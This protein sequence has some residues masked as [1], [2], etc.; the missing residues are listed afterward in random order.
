M[1]LPT[2]MKEFK[3][4]FFFG[5]GSVLTSASGGAQPAM[6]G[7]SRMQPIWNTMSIEVREDGVMI[8]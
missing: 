4:L 7:S 2:S 1:R 8:T 6:A 3:S 5:G